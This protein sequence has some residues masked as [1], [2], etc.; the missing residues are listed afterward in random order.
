MKRTTETASNLGAGRFIFSDGI[1]LSRT[2]ICSRRQKTDKK[3]AYFP[4]DDLG[5]RGFRLSFLAQEL[6][7]ISFPYRYRPE[8][9]PRGGHIWGKPDDLKKKFLSQLGEPSGD[10]EAAALGADI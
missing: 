7:K 8:E 2:L 5:N 6:G 10:W 4:F 9:H 1:L 3:L